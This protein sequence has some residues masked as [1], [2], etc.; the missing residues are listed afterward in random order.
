MDKRVLKLD[1]F[2]E[3]LEYIQHVSVLQTSGDYEPLSETLIEESQTRHQLREIA[4]LER[5][6]HPVD[7]EDVQRLM[8]TIDL[9]ISSNNPLKH[10]L[11]N[12][13]QETLR[14]HLT[15][16]DLDRMVARADFAKEHKDYLVA[17]T[18]LYEAIIAIAMQRP[19]S[20]LYDEDFYDKRRSNAFNQLCKKLGTDDS[21]TLRAFRKVRNSI[22]HANP[23]L[24]DKRAEEALQSEQGIIDL[25]DEVR[26]IFAKLRD[27]LST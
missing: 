25:Y 6:N 5:V 21:K 8:E 27:T 17:Y 10:D 12:T 19:D 2:P 11:L 13:L 14:K 15:S 22:V 24:D 26:Q 18:L 1:L 7:Y 23:V 3:L 16:S 20:D 4:F 9:S